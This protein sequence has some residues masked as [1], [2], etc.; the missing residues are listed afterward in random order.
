MK[1]YVTRKIP[2]IG[3]D[4]L[5]K[6]GH[7]VE[8]SPLDRPL[9]REELKDAVAGA[10]GILSQLV[11]QIDG[12]I[13]DAAGKQ[14]KIVANYAVGFDNINIKDAQ[15]RNVLVTNTPDILTGSVADHAFGLILA[16]G[17]RI[18][19]SDRFSRAGKYQGWQPFLLLGQ[20]VSEKTLGI[21]GLG[22]I[23]STLA[24]RASKGFGMKVVYYDRDS[25]NKDL[26]QE[27]GARA[28]SMEELLK[29]S[30]FISVHVPLTPETKHLISTP[31]F[32]LMKKTAVLINTS[33]GPVVDEQALLEALQKQDIFGAG[34]DVWEHEPELTP[35]L[36]ELENIVIT[37]HTASATIETRDNMSRVA[38][39]N[40]NAALKG[41]TP[42]N[43]VK[44]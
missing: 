29:T 8:V 13:L 20:D 42:P 35:G 22:K 3:I 9:S 10:D 6:A 19:E 1:I 21:I 15:V 44:S 25:V 7:E 41:Q 27:I 32:E 26:D 16:V 14:L 2:Q 40:I 36:A 4:V 34:I 33:R 30:D 39:E 11:D 12:E 17:R 5:E 24:R 38:A 23:G 37:P 28:V 31:Q 18:V 43:L